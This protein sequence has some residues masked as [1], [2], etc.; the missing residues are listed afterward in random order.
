MSTKPSLPPALADILREFVNIGVGRAARG[1][2]EL[3]AREVKMRV[4]TLEVLDPNSDTHLGEIGSGVTL[5]ISQA[6]SGGL[7]GQ[8]LLVLN[9]AGAISLA[10]LLLG[11]GVGDEAFDDQEQGA[12]LE[13]GNIIIGNVMGIL[14]NE[15]DSPVYYELPQLQLRGIHSYIDLVADLCDTNHSRLIRMR[16]SLAI[17][18]EEINGHLILIFPESGLLPLIAKLTCLANR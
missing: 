2:S 18:T 11:K 12:L 8:A 5:R 17:E 7:N 14:A 4:P 16:A 3:T 13:L 10:K 1:L 9:R 6:F 15:L